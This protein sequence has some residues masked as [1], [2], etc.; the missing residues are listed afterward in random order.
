MAKDT[1]NFLKV[2]LGLLHSFSEFSVQFNELF[3]NS[4]VYFQ[5]V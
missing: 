5:I 2:F 3:W 4:I 1:N